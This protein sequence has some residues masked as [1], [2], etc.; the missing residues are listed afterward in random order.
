MPKHRV[1]FMCSPL[2]SP[3]LFPVPQEEMERGLSPVLSPTDGQCLGKLDRCRN[4]SEPVTKGWC[5]PELLLCGTLP[6]QPQPT[7]PRQCLTS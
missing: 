2:P 1:H 6:T 3:V 5:F 7:G 4:P